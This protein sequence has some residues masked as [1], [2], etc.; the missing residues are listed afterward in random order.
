MSLSSRSVVPIVFAAVLGGVIALATARGRSG[1]AAATAEAP[2]PATP[3]ETEP[4]AERQ[5]TTSSLRPA[6]S[7]PETASA[8]P[9]SSAAPVASASAAT[10][11]SA[12]AEKAPTVAQT[13]AIIAPTT[14]EALHQAELDCDRKK[15]PEACERVS[16][17]LDSGSAGAKDPSRAEKLRRI[18]L[19][20]Y[21][22]Q[23]EGD[24]ALSCTRL[25]EM[26]ERGEIVQK[27]PKN[28]KALRARVLDLCRSKPNQIGCQR[29]Q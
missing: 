18:A 24:R 28:A 14:P 7:A 25:A 22:R 13:V 10:A 21:V 8:A 15:L 12:G 17:A 2:A 23:C 1:G 19:T 27:N 3:I 29:E 6:P 5:S 26:Y 20:L 16:L 4:K 9:Q 11:P